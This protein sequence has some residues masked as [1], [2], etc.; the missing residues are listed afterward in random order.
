MYMGALRNCCCSSL[1]GGRP[2]VAQS[3]SAAQRVVA[4]HYGV[5]TARRT[6]PHIDS[7]LHEEEEEHAVG[8]AAAS[9]RAGSLRRDWLYHGAP[10]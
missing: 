1:D 5:P 8:K 6:R 3:S 7:A 4:Q 10:Y 2:L 9:A